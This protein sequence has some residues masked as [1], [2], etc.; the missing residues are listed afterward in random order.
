MVSLV[1][2]S[3]VVVG[4]VVDSRAREV[5]PGGGSVASP[6]EPS[7]SVVGVAFAVVLKAREGGSDSVCPVGGGG[8]EEVGRWP[9]GRMGRGGGLS[10]HRQLRGSRRTPSR[11]LVV[12]THEQLSLSHAASA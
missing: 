10:T 2:S 12:Q 4:A 1:K 9:G 8:E 11:H 6:A 3:S 7:S 5:G